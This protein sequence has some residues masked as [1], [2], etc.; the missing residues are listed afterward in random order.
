M[1]IKAFPLI[2]SS[3]EHCESWRL[4]RLYKFLQIYLLIHERNS[5]IIHLHDHE[6]TLEVHLKYEGQLTDYELWL[7]KQIWSLLDSGGSIKV[8]TL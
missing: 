4:T 8:N 1:D 2:S 3:S 7:I 5:D 6:G